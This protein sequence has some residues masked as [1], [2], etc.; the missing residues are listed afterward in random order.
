M[1]EFC[2]ITYEL[3]F[4]AAIDVNV[5]FPSVGMVGVLNPWVLQMGYPVVYV[6]RDSEDRNFL[7]ITQ[8]RFLLDPNANIHE[9]ES[10]YELVYIT[11]TFKRYCLRN[12]NYLR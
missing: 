12:E 6:G 2:A 5:S 11:E 4:Q 3:L 8:E 9:P 1:Y 10:P 7:K